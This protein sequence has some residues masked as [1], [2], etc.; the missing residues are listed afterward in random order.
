MFK[1]QTSAGLFSNE[2]DMLLKDEDNPLAP[3]FSVLNQLESLRWDDGTLHLK[4]CYPR[5]S[6]LGG[7]RCNIWTQHT[8]PVMDHNI[9]NF[10]KIQLAF[11]EGFQ[12]LAKSYSDDR[13]IDDGESGYVIGATDYSNPKAQKKIPGPFHPN[14]YINSGE[15]IFAAGDLNTVFFPDFLQDLLGA[16]RCPPKGQTTQD[17]LPVQEAAFLVRAGPSR[18][19]MNINMLM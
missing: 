1:H 19:L 14:K 10:T 3:L 16:R 2:D 9:Q 8:N 17:Q 6:G 12:G 13:L 5:L 4:I 11:P 18:A 7:R 15:V